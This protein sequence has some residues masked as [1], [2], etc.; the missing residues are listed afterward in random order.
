MLALN[1]IAYYF[2]GVRAIIV[3]A[4]SVG[5]SVVTEYLCDC[6][7]KKRFDWS[8]TSS[9]MSGMLLALMMPASVPYRVIIFA[10]AVM[11][12]VFK[13][14]FGGRNNLIFSPAAAAY[15]LAVIT[16]PAS[17]LR[18]PSPVPF[19]KLPLVSDIPDVLGR[20]FT[21][22]ADN[23]ISSASYLDIVWGK[24]AGPMGTSCALVILIC[25]VSLYFFKDIPSPVFFSAIAVEVLLFVLFPFSATGWQAMLYSLVT[26]SFLFVLTFMACDYRFV[27]ERKLAQIIYGGA[28]AALSFVLRKYA[29]FEN[30][31]VFALLIVSIFVSELDRF[32]IFVTANAE[33]F[34]AFSASKL[35]YAM[36]FVKFRLGSKKAGSEPSTD[37]A[38][39]EESV[40][41]V[42]ESAGAVSESANGDNDKDALPGDDGEAE[43]NV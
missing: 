12:S 10:S 38:G 30:G 23:S 34:L 24:L 33:R 3:S 9:V 28:F 13:C 20:S 39:S 11:S 19:G 31:A 27:P 5:V 35:R 41:A 36:I 2:Y 15:A 8:D 16:W 4:I 21:Y 40:D 14:A 17:I 6:L 29:G 1:V 42:S 18:Y 25:A 37:V 22:Y 32:D 7:M 26:G 43:K